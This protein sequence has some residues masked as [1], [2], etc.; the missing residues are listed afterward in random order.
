MNVDA[1]LNEAICTGLSEYFEGVPKLLLIDLAEVVDHAL[2]ATCITLAKRG[3]AMFSFDD[4][5]SVLPTVADELEDIMNHF[6]HRFDRERFIVLARSLMG[7][8]N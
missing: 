4:F 6:G 5:A 8:L 3:V 7:G 2:F 1:D